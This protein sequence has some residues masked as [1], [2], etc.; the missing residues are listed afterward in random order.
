MVVVQTME[1][2]VVVAVSLDLL[3]PLSLLGVSPD[4]GRRRD[5]AGHV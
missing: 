4:A 5:R 1:V 3:S 2:R